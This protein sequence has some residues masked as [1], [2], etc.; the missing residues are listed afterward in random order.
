VNVSTVSGS[1][2]RLPPQR[3]TAPSASPAVVDA[4]AA[5]ATS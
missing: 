2:G 5:I 1:S 3:S 4:S